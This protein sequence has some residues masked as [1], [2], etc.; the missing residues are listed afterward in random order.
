MWLGSPECSAT[1]EPSTSLPKKLIEGYETGL[2]T[3]SQVNIT[4]TYGHI[5]GMITV[6]H[7]DH[8]LPPN[9]KKAK[10]T[11][12]SPES[13]EGYVYLTNSICVVTYLCTVVEQ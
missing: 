8:A 10:Q 6:T 3:E 2:R 5:S 11:R 4:A 9:T 13:L 12:P 7:T 1:W